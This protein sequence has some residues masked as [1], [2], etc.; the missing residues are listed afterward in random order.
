[1]TAFAHYAEC[2]EGAEKSDDSLYAANDEARA[3][4]AGY[5]AATETLIP[6]GWQLVPKEPT[7]EMVK[8][9]NAIASEMVDAMVSRCMGTLG[10][11]EVQ[12]EYSEIATK[13]AQ[14]AFDSVVGIC[15]AMLAAAPEYKP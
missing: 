1:M 5:W 13:Y 7:E 2:F 3:F 10:G 4:F 11:H 12:E 8:A 9:G 6:N 14:G 15:K